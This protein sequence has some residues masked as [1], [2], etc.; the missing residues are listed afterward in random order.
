MTPRERWLAVLNGQRADRVPTDYWATGEVTDRL[1]AE[2]GCV[3]EM[4]LYRK[5]GIDR[6]I[7]VGPRYTGPDFGEANMWGVRR[8]RQEYAGGAGAYDEV[9]D[10]PLAG[11]TTV[12]QIDSHPWPSPDWYD[13]TVL[14]GRIAALP[15]WPIRAASYEPFL[16]YCHL[17]GQE[18]ALMDLAMFPDLAEAALTRIFDFHYTLAQRTFESADPGSIHVTYVAEDLGTQHSLLMS[19]PMV[20][21]FLK[22]NMKRMIDLAHSFGVKA[23]HHDDGACRPLLGGLIEIGIDILNPIQWRCPGMDRRE[24]M[25]EFGDCLVFHGGVDNQHTIPFGTPDD[26]RAEVREN[27]E[28]FGRRYICAPC[29]NI[30]PITPTANIVALYQAAHEYGAIP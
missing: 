13:F 14:P 25:A 19:E 3:D 4:V 21:R 22:P 7:A 27:I 12:A 30:Q 5:L 23:M 18:Q 29:H 28:I 6:L 17:R 2:L 10:Y 15:E 24:L 1:L 11:A 16:L 9:V 20:N 8:V 26:V